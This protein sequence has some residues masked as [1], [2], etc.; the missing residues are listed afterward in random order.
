MSKLSGSV[1]VTG[2]N[3]FLG[4]HAVDQTLKLTNLKV[5][6]IVRSE[7]STEILR[8]A[9]PKEIQ[10]GRLEFGFVPQIDSEGAYDEAIKGEHNS[11]A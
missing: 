7:K 6:A 1:L 2:A 8:N 3:G 4:Q 5:K 9:F 11:Y 10:E